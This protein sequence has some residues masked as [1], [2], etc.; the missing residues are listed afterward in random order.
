M[1][2]LMY[3]P[4]QIFGLIADIVG[5]VMLFKYGLPE[6]ERTGG[7]EKITTSR[8]DELAIRLEAKYDCMGKVGLVLIVLGFL[9][10]LASSLIGW[11]H[12]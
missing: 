7:A 10:Q 9:M 5:V 4:L 8:V 2:Y 6:I 1:I 11:A 3:Y 12:Q